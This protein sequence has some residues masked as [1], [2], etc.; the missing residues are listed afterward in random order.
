MPEIA[1]AYRRFADEE[2][3][4]RSPLYEELARGVADDPAVIAFLRTLPPDKRQPNL[5]LA[6]SRHLFG[7]PD[8]WT[9]FR[10]T[11]LDRPAALAALMRRRS[12]QTNEAGRC[13]TLLPV[14]ARLP[15]PLALIEVGASAGLCLLPDFYGY[16]YHGDGGPGHRIAA[17]C[18]DA[19]VLR[20][21]ADP[22]TPLPDGPPQVAWRAGLDLNPLDATDAEDVSWL[23][24]L[25]WPEQTERLARLQAALAVAARQR[26]RVVAGDLRHDLAALAAD[27]PPDATLVVFHTAVLS[28]VASTADRDAFAATVAGLRARWIANESPRVLPAIAARAGPPP[29]AGR[30]LLSVDGQ[31]CAWTDPHGTALDWIADGPVD[32][33]SYLHSQGGRTNS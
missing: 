25:V 29:A 26:P 32:H 14:L 2:A 5:L 30:F 3:R 24:T 23:E 8:G 17:A 21:R 13:A 22:A 10:R 6:A 9:T 28:Y 4:G 33:E 16:D 31:P 11:L 20:C 12:T 19:P 1:A 18:R 27:A 15:Q 7:T